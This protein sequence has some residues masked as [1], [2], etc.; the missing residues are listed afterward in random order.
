MSSGAGAT[1]DD[2]SGDVSTAANAQGLPCEMSTLLANKCTSCHG[3]TPLFGAPMPLVTLDD[4]R[5]PAKS[6]P[7]RKVYELVGE[8][9]RSTAKPMPPDVTQRLDAGELAM[10]DTW[11]EA[12]APAASPGGT[13]TPPT[14]PSLPQGAVGET[15]WPSDCEDVH[16]LRVHADADPSQKFHVTPDMNNAYFCWYFASPWGADTVQ[17]LEIR[18]ALDQAKVVHHWLLFGT[19]DLR[20]EPGTVRSCEGSGE[21]DSALIAAWAPGRQ[22]VVL[23]PDVGLEMPKGPNAG[24]V[25]QIHY[26]ANGM[27]V[28]DGT[29]VD[30]CTSN[31]FRPNN[32]GISWLGSVDLDLPPGQETTIRGTCRP[33]SRE[34]IHILRIWPHMHSLG[35]QMQVLVHRGGGG[36]SEML[37]DKPFDFEFQTSWE[38]P[39]VVMPGDSIETICRYENTGDARVG[40]GEKT[41]DEMCFAYTYAYPAGALQDD[42]PVLGGVLGRR[43]FCVGY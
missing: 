28:M 4:L 43:N 17:S 12:A 39:A 32:A 36:A 18:S 34:P 2:R 20:E 26:Y 21:Y 31:S 19:D 1:P 8:R 15:P 37:L 14:I 25:F 6:D 23:P 27:D 22:D 38:T 5:A 35:R 3:A 11:I 13:C 7:T 24:L 9:V 33:A 16:G 10:V 30:I 42:S 41:S 29:G 40:F